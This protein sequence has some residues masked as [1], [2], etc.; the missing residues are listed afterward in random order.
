MLDSAPQNW[1]ATSFT[2]E[3]PTRVPVPFD[4]SYKPLK[5]LEATPGIEPGCAVLAAVALASGEGQK[6]P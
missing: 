1:R 5:L 4:R 2:D 6:R 3:A